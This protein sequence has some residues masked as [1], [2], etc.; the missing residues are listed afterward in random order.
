MPD[1]V[2][3]PTWYARVYV[4]LFDD[5]AHAAF[6][7][8]MAKGRAGTIPKAAISKWAAKMNLWQSNAESRHAT[9]AEHGC[10]GK[11]SPA[12]VTHDS[13]GAL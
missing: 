3:M 11:M 12:C 1:E 2:F 4:M 5:V 13:I 8:T 10:V 6:L 9:H 7:K